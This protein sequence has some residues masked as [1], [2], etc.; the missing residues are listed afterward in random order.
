M[1]LTILCV[2]R[3]QPH[4]GRFLQAFDDLAATLDCELVEYDGTR[5][6]AIEDVL[7]DAIAECQDGYILRLDDDE[8]PSPGM[9]EWL[10]GCAYETAD[11][12]CFPRLHLWRD[13]HHYI[14]TPPLYPDL[15]TRLSIREKSGGRSRVHD[16]SPFG[17]G[18]R[19]PVAIEHHKFLVRRREEREALLNEYRRLR[20]DAD[21]WMIYTVP[22]LFAQSLTVA[23]RDERPLPLTTGKGVRNG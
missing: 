10:R 16:G 20:H 3:Y 5:A 6:R 1:T 13:I 11:H 17:S 22:E 14:P 4:A 12:W 19:A 23:E 2:T 8:L 21:E 18:E 15:Q 9:V 7:D